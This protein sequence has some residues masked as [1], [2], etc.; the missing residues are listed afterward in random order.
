MKK[1]LLSLIMLLLP[2]MASAYDVVLND[3]Y[4]N[5][6]TN[7]KKATVTYAYSDY[8]SY[9]GSVTIPA[10]ITVHGVTYSVNSIGDYAFARCTELTSIEIPS[11]VTSIGNNAFTKCS[12]LPSVTLQNSLTT[13]GDR[14]FSE[15]TSLT[16]MTIPSSVTSLGE[17]IFYRC[18]ALVS[19]E[20]PNG[21]TILKGNTF[22]GCSKL[23]SVNIP[24]SVTH[25]DDYAFSGCSALEDIEIPEGVKGI[26]TNAFYKCTGLTSIVIPSSVT[27][28]ND[29]AFSNCTN[30]IQVTINSDDVVMNTETSSS[31]MDEYFGPQV[32]TYII[33]DKVT[34]IGE[35]AF[36]GC[37]R[38]TSIV[39]PSS[40]T[41]IGHSAFNGCSGLT[42]IE[43]PKNVTV[44]DYYAFYAC[45]NLQEVYC[46][47]ENV[48]TTGEGIFNY[49][50]VSTAS[51]YVPTGSV[52]A[53]KEAEQW[54][55]FGNIVP[56]DVTE[57]QNVDAAT[58][59]QKTEQIFTLDGK[60]QNKLQ[61][62]I[63]IVKY[64]DGTTRK[65]MVK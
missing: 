7:T 43:I 32:E 18:T 53:Y 24:S 49:S 37:S 58:E 60:P 42:S 47:A 28:V 34:G 23:T 55:D 4:Y 12:S 9:S 27:S 14:A 19:V 11:S 20:V 1:Q 54:K 25:I 44:I 5:L 65:E 17:G 45:D 59:A 16:S 21:I 2:L 36:D 52:N 38:M 35:N 13:I 6:N 64:S 56:F 40:V 22:Y 33:G 10:S 63:N 31:N 8:V 15:C 39:I 26:D 48:P 29:Y 46:M 50:P 3:I 57:I 62:G 30:L 51:L 61:K 41:S